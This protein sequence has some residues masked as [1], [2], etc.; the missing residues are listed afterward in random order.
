MLISVYK[1]SL[2][3]EQFLKANQHR[4]AASFD[5]CSTLPNQLFLGKGLETIE[6]K[7]ISVTGRS[8]N[9]AAI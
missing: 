7:K 1:Y 9:A 4:F 6:D 3:V 8:T 5:C 2:N